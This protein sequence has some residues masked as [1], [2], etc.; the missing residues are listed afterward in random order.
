LQLADI[1]NDT[2]DATFADVP[3][4]VIAETS[5]IKNYYDRNYCFLSLIEKNG[6]KIEAKLDAVIWRNSYHIIRDFEKDTNIKFDKNLKL[7]LLVSVTF[8]GQY[9]L[10]LSVIGI[11]NTYTLGNLELQRQQVLEKLIAESYGTIQF[12]GEN[13]ITQNK[14]LELPTVIKNIALIT[15]PNSDGQRDFVHELKNNLLGF[16]FNIDEY[17]TTIQG[18]TAAKNILI[19]LAEIANGKQIYDVVI[20]I[21]GGGSQTDFEVFEHYELAKTI[22]GFSIPIFTGIGHQRNV[23]IADMMSNMSFKTPTKVANYIFENN[24]LFFEE[25]QQLKE[26]LVDISI[27]ILSSEKEQ[28]LSD[29]QQLK[30]SVNHIIT[31]EKHQLEKLSLTVKLL[32]PKNVLAR[33]YAIITKNNITL[34]DGKSLSKNDEIEIQFLNEAIQATIN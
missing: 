34:I 28:I 3:L 26:N 22:A 4:W 8:S 16:H 12:D 10:K 18:D 2:I 1:I 5:D 30:E 17:L 23:S 13:Y 15:A 27:S 7:L 29:K 24:K 20:I 32:S 9:G 31:N 11:D 19:K 33:G 21:R 14:L 25:L 6:A